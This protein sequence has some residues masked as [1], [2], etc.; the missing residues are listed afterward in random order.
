MAT[1]C[2]NHIS[3]TTYLPT[4]N[5]RQAIPVAA[6]FID[7]H[8]LWHNTVTH[9]SLDAQGNSRIRHGPMSFLF[10]RAR[11]R[12]AADLPK[13]AREHVLKLDGPTGTAKVLVELC[14]AYD[15]KESATPAGSVLRELLKNEAAAAVILYDD[16][17]APG[18]SAKGLNAIDRDRP[19]SGRG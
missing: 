9:F 5:S 13:Q 12:T 18:S 8:H 17:D 15:H 3:A 4:P 1:I 16:G 6:T 7:I 11:A 14:R 2:H 10:G 19:Q